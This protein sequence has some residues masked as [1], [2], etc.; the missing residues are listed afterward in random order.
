[1][2]LNRIVFQVVLIAGP[3]LAGVITAWSRAARLLPG[4][5]GV[6]RGGAVGR[7]PA[8]R[9]AARAARRRARQVRRATVRPET[10]GRDSAAGDGAAADEGRPGRGS[11]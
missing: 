10:Y 2:A 8:A 9:D 3:A 11:R 5:R 4:G 6:V 1:M 7:G